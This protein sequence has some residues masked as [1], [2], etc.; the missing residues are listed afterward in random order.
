MIPVVKQPD[1]VPV[2][3]IKKKKKNKLPLIIILVIVIAGILGTGGYFGFKLLNRTIITKK[4][5]ESNN[6]FEEANE[7][8]INEKY[9]GMLEDDFTEEH[10][11][12]VFTLDE[13]S[14]VYVKFYCEEQFYTDDAYWD[15]SLRTEEKPDERLTEAFIYGNAV[16][17]YLPAV[18]LEK[19]TYYVVIESSTM[20]SSDEYSFEVV[21]ED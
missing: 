2:D 14:N 6:S 12:Y 20:Y 15:V 13:K 18:E 17:G 21:C 7:I 19:G 8:K 10:D 4:E 16:M 1:P 11:C 5:V 9:T 3:K